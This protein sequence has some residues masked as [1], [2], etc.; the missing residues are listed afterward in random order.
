LIGGNRDEFRLGE[1]LASIA[2]GVLKPVLPRRL[3]INPAT[4]IAEALVEAAVVPR[5]GIHV[6]TSVELA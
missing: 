2:L 5:P 6:V 4:K 1:K 3:R